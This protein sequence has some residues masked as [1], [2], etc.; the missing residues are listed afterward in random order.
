[1]CLV[2]VAFT[3]SVSVESQQHWLN[4]GP[5]LLLVCTG[6]CKSLATW[7]TGFP[8]GVAEE[9]DGPAGRSL[10]RDSCDQKRGWE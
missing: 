2:S 5:S 4:S 3:L 9:G 10:L 1:M 6:V 8:V 7:E